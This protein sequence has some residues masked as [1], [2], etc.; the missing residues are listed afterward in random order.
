MFEYLLWIPEKGELWAAHL[1]RD[2]WQ[3]AGLYVTVKK[4]LNV[5]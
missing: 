5:Y 2:V 1:E 3:R 4:E